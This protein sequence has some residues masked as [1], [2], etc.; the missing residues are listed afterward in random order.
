MEILKY[1][2]KNIVNRPVRAA[3]II[4]AGVLAGLVMVFSASLGIEVA[5]NNKKDII[6]KLTGHLWIPSNKGKIEFKE[7][8]RD[9]YAKE[10]KFIR[11]YLGNHPNTENVVGWYLGYHEMQVVTNR[12][13]TFITATDFETDTLYCERTELVEGTFPS[14]KEPY[15]CIIS[16][17]LT[18]KYNLTL[19]D[20]VV[21]FIP[22]AF[23]ARNAMDFIITGIF[24]PSAPYYEGVTIHIN[25]CIEMTELTGISPFYKA[26]VK[27]ENLI[28]RMVEE[29]KAHVTDFPVEGYKDDPFI[30]A[31]LSSGTST[32]V[33]FG[34]LALILFF[35]L[36]IG[37]NS[38]IM[39]N[40]FDRRDE[41][42]TLRALGFQRST[43]R[44]I[45]FGE[46]VIQLLIGYIIGALIV[47]GL[48][49]FF[50]IN[51]V[52]P[53]LLVL[54]Y[55]FGMTRMGLAINVYSVVVPF[56]LLFGI[57]ILTTT[58]TIG[59]ETEKQAVSQMA[60]H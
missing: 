15:T 43:V 51:L 55:L 21:L 26:Y 36:L 52:R 38:V 53:P 44:N 4:V 11:E 23:G 47:A 57:M 20:S 9:R 27:N 59:K 60:N 29:L 22:S 13:Y 35:A 25:D 48:G 32:L 50:Q 6:A 37:I 54:E 14:V 19:G 16:T 1:I 39:T 2:L 7:E 18:G 17:G 58:R 8:Y 33:F 5:D 42:G 41:I 45:F 34:T 10:A 30:R 28:P 40:I 49:I 46:T 56:L 31:L 3:F 12:I 24:R